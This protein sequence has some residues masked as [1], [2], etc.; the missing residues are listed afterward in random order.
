MPDALVGNKVVDDLNAIARKVIAPYNITI[1]DL[2]R[3]VHSHCGDTYSDCDWCRRHPCSYHYNAAGESA[4]ADAVASAFRA[5][6]S[7][8]RVDFGRKANDAASKKTRKSAIDALP[9]G[10]NFYE[11]RAH[12]EL[13]GAPEG[14]RQVVQ[15]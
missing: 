13:Q 4:Q 8:P 3:L 15:K 1:L 10:W 2:N 11:N 14:K 12:K 9:R 5:A 6:L 7:E